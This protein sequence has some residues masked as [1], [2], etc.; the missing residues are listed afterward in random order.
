MAKTSCSTVVPVAAE[1]VWATLARFEDIS[2]WGTGVSQSSIL[3]QRT[4]GL[5][6]TRR[7]QVGRNTLRETVTVWEPS[8]ALGYSIVGLP[9]VVREAANTWTLTGDGD[10]TTV[11]LASEVTTKGGPL[12]SHLVAGRIAKANKQLLAGLVGHVSAGIGS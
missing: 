11:T 10:S 5:G 4:E 8:R 7:V 9:P 6:A 3:T 2:Q 12:L 1:V